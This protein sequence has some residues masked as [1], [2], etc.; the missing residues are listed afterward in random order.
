MGFS[1]DAGNIF[2]YSRSKT[3]PPRPNR[4]SRYFQFNKTAGNLTHRRRIIDQFSGHVLS[5]LSFDQWCFELR[6]RMSAIMAL[7]EEQNHEA[8]TRA[9]QRVN[10]WVTE[11][12]VELRDNEQLSVLYPIKL[13]ID[14]KNER[15]TRLKVI[16]QDTPAFLYSL[17]TALSLHGISIENVHIRTV[18]GRIEDEISF[19][20]LT[21]KP[22]IDEDKLNKVRFSVLFTKQFTYFLDRAPAP[23]TALARFEQLLQEILTLPEKGQWLEL[24]ANPKALNDLARLL[25]TSDYIWEDFIRLQYE[26]LLP[27]LGA[28]VTHKTFSESGDPLN[29]KLNNALAG[30][31]TY[32]SKQKALNDFK[33]NEIYLIDLDHILNPQVND[34]RTLATR[35]TSLAEIVICAATDIIFDHMAEKYGKP[36][37]VAGLPAHY[38]LLGLGK[39]GGAALGYAS[40]MELLLAYSDQ[41]HTDGRDSITNSEFY[42]KLI[43]ELSK[44]IESKRE[45]IFRVDLRL[46]PYGESGPLACSLES[47]IKYYGPDSTAHSFEKLA[48][49]RMRAIGG[50]TALG[51]RIERLRDEFIYASSS[52]DIE[53]LHELR[54]RQFEEKK[55]GSEYNAKFSPGALVDLEY[56]VQILQVLYAAKTHALKTPRIHIA[57]EELNKAGILD[58]EESERLTEAYDFLRRLINGLR[59]LRGSAKDLFP[60]PLLT[61]PSLCIWPVAWVYE[62]PTRHASIATNSIW[63]LNCEPPLCVH[64]FVKHFGRESLPGPVSGKRR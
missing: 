61:H 43:Q 31:K 3:T 47:F 33:N 38:S 21:G 56:T 26:A 28:D 45:G 13:D 54:F 53:E 36:K 18:E 62:K 12:L 2:T 24:L 44:F 29:I 27:I 34:F 19:V 41:G 49:V 39:L 14:N 55:R 58:S 37:T 35:L 7:L 42:G 11:R 9:K 20:D 6:E 51:A 57:L 40:D 60:P 4:F 30:A 64:S 10:E 32:E 50:D 59:I 15:M 52:I 63:S 17:S 22:V 5:Q 8:T 16:S 48:L 25:G 1:I 46:R 23:Y